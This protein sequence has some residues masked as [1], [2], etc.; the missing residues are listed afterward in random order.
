MV[1][2][3]G[4]RIDP[5]AV[6]APD[7]VQ[8]RRFVPRLYEHFAAAD[9]AVVQGGGTTTLE[10][11]ALRTPFLYFPLEHHFEQNIVVAERVARHGAGTRMRYS[12][13]TPESLAD[14]IGA[15]VGR[16]RGARSARAAP[17]AP[18]S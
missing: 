9:V 14:A 4:P 16:P 8:L 6:E 11:T 1:L 12:D 17:R 7:G 3:C 5:A 15:H 18:P 13:T 10:L 2:V